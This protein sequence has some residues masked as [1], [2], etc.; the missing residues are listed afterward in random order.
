MYTNGHPLIRQAY[1][2]GTSDRS[3]LVGV[4]VPNEAALQELGIADDEK[5]I[6]A[7]LRDAIKEVARNEQLNAYE[8][9]R[10]F[11]VERE[12][13]SVENGLLTGIGK[14]QRPKFKERYGARLEKLYDDIAASQSDELQALRCDGRNGPVLETLARAVQA[15]LGI[16]DEIDLS[17]AAAASPSLA[18]IRCPRSPAPSCSRKSTV[19]KFPP[20]LSTIRRATCSKWRRSSSADAA[21]LNVLRLLPCMAAGRRRSARAT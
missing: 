17:K 3:Y 19:S 12:P 15:T 6:K 11:I 5:A 1:L 14:Y 10:D 7:A 8:V 2:Y 4:F 13:F 18:A 16:D 20:V 21:T 9:P